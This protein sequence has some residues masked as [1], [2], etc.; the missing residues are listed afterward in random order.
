MAALIRSISTPTRDL[1]YSQTRDG[2]S[3]VALPEFSLSLLPETQFPSLHLSTLT[4][5][6]S[7]FFFFKHFPFNPSI[8]NI[9]FLFPNPFPGLSA[10]HTA[11][12]YGVPL[13]MAVDLSTNVDVLPG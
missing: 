1:A 4:D 9:S 8:K 12:L 3:V 7:F 2:A 11:P 6:Q 13:F 5:R 10:I